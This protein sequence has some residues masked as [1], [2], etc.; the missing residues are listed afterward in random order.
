M[1]SYSALYTHVNSKLGLNSLLDPWLLFQCHLPHYP[2]N[3][4]FSG[5]VSKIIT[6]VLR[7]VYEKVGM[8][9]SKSIRHSSLVWTLYSKLLVGGDPSAEDEESLLYPGQ[10][11]GRKK[12][13]YFF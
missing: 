1:S 3:Y 13:L 9:T 10:L 11:L 7:K 2:H 8:E 5:Y 12:C 6:I 4:P